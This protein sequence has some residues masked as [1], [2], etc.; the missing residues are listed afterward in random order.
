[1]IRLRLSLVL[2]SHI[3]LLQIKDSLTSMKADLT[4]M[5]SNWE[6]SG[7]GEGGIAP[8]PPPPRR[9]P[10]TN[11]FDTDSE[12]D[13]IPE[14][15]AF[16]R[17]AGRPVRAMDCR[18]SFLNGRS[19]YLLIYWEVADQHQ[20]LTVALQRLSDA[21]SAVDASS[22]PATVV[23][24]RPGGGSRSSTPMNDDGNA[25][26]GNLGKSVNRYDAN[27]NVRMLHASIHELKLN[28][29]DYGATLSRSTIPSEQ[30]YYTEQIVAMTN[31]I[32]EL[33]AKKRK[34]ERIADNY[35]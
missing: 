8:P 27:C 21:V 11:Q 34:Y 31:E 29:R 1:V 18:E 9:K 25:L 2:F 19:S 14:T 10:F 32:E 15:H 12:D 33:E 16:G 23:M 24:R 26:L 7:Q 35:D 17:L 13:E 3:G 5:I 22:A 20:L 30:L 6:Q 4:R 28:K